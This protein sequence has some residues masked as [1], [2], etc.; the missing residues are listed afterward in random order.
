MSHDAL[1]SLIHISTE[2]VRH[3]A[4]E[5]IKRIKATRCKKRL[6]Y[7]HN[8]RKKEIKKIRFLRKI[9][10]NLYKGKLASIKNIITTPIHPFEQ[11]ELYHVC[12]YGSEKES[13]CNKIINY[14][15]KADKIYLTL[16]DL[17][18]IS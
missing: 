15:D 5:K 9:T 7:Y 12:H 4:Q 1:Q 18:M 3:L 2:T 6:E 8:V 13:F 14:C 16:F 17:E 11:I 10:F